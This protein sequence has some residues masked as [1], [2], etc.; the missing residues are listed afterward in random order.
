MK[1]EFEQAQQDYEDF[2]NTYQESLKKEKPKELNEDDLR[3][4]KQTYRKATKLCHPDKVTDDQKELAQKVFN[5][6]KEAYDNNDLEK[7]KSIL[8]DLEKGFFKS[9]GETITIKEKLVLIKHQLETKRK[10]LE[11]SLKYLKNTEIHRKV[12]KI[13]NW[14][15]YFEET[16]QQFQKM[17]EELEVNQ[18]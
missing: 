13:D 8:S 6:L 15:I 4:L 12:I 2:Y 18:D 7:V 14:E 5:D 16:K 11:E 17:I 9:Q 10:A 1:T 3:I